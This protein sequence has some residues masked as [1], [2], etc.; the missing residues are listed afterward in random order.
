MRRKLYVLYLLSQGLDIR[1]EM[2]Y[3]ISQ[4]EGVSSRTGALRRVYD[5]MVDK[6]LISRNVLK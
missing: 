1:L 2:D 3:L 6:N 5:S 4:V